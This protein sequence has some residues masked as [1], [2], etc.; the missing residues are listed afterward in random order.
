M[1]ALTPTLV[2]VETEGDLQVVNLKFTTVANGDTFDATKFFKNVV[3]ISFASSGFIG[4]AD[5]SGTLTFSTTSGGCT[6]TFMRL[7]GN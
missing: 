7:C 3:S 1:A 6:T 5:S 4:I 2:K